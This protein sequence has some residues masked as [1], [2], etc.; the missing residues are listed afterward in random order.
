ML[1]FLAVV[2]A[3]LAVAGAAA[4]APLPVTPG[5]I[6]LIEEGHAYVFR[7][8]DSLPLYTFD[9]DAPGRSNCTG[10]CESLWPPLLARAGSAPLGEWTLVKRAD[11]K[12]QW[13]WRGRPLYTYA[14]DGVDKPAGDGAGGVWHVIPP[15]AK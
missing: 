1:R 2:T 5:D 13:A 4:A 8:N 15:I 7:S 12:L 14:K 11:G 3:G 6:S 9:K 10:P